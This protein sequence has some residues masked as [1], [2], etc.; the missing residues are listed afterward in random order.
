MLV[1]D[2][3]NELVALEAFFRRLGFDVFS[4]GKDVLLSDAL[5]RFPPDLAIASVKGRLVDGVKI[6]SRLK[7]HAPSPKVALT[8]HG[9]VPPALQSEAQTV[10]D[11]LVE[12]PFNPKQV[13]RIV[14][15]LLSMEAEP[16]LA[17]FEKQSSAKFQSDDAMRIITDEKTSGSIR[18]SGGVPDP[19][20]WDPIRTPGLAS[21]ARSERSSGYDRFLA[22]H[23][24]GD[25]SG[26]LP[27]AQAAAAMEKLKKDSAPEREALERL[28]EQKR[29]FVKTLFES[30]A[31]KK[32]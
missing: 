21:T 10:V 2:D 26:V 31:R 29:Q 1:I 15:R 27:H 24:D 25:V 5:L 23:D 9:N 3:Y 20:G 28:D 30:G 6:A 4:L 18:V 8:Y 19:M 12:I 17:K 13:I 22:T 7:R 14:A 16:L 32:I 11:A